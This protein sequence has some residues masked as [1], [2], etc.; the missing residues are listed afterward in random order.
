M[1][2]YTQVGPTVALLVWVQVKLMVIGPLPD[3]PVLLLEGVTVCVIDPVVTS[4][5]LL[6]VAVVVV[7]PCAVLLALGD[8]SIVRLQPLFELLAEGDTMMVFPVT[9]PV[10]VAEGLL[11]V[12]E[13]PPVVVLVVVEFELAVAAPDPDPSLADPLPADA[14]DGPP[15]VVFPVDDP[16]AA[17]LLATVPG[18]A[19]FFAPYPE[20]DEG[21]P[22]DGGSS[23]LLP[24][25]AVAVAAP[26]VVVAI[27]LVEPEAPELVTLA[28]PLAVNGAVTLVAPTVA[29]LPC[30]AVAL[31]VVGPP[32][33]VAELLLVGVTVWM[34]APLL[35]SHSDAH[36]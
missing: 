24:V 26:P 4:P 10:P 35:P 12:L 25:V 22:N 1:G 28:V 36:C 18:I 13:L 11:V 7:V 16:A 21:S 32:P 2:A 31:T 9:D 27:V 30:V 33:A 29:E 20:A 14:V 19:A 17:P 6:V 5:L 15:L 8:R 23:L 34:I 3:V